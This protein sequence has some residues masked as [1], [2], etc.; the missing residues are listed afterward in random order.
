VCLRYDEDM[1]CGVTM[2]WGCGGADGRLAVMRDGTEV[3]TFA[4][5]MRNKAWCE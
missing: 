5:G 3:D 1:G 4:G 2:V